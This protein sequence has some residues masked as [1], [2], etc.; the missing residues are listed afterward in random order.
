MAKL[1]HEAK[2]RGNAAFRESDADNALVHYT[3]ALNLAA[4]PSAGASPSE[5]AMLFSNRAAAQL[6]LGDF[7]AALADAEAAVGLDQKNAKAHYRKAQALIGLN[8]SDDAA[9]GLRAAVELL[10]GEQALADQ[11]ATV[12]KALK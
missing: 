6:K 12:Q 11:L 10:P 5:R 7:K 2:E 9:S 1:S 8:R 3:R 4:V